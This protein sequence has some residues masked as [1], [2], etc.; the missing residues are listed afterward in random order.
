MERI[1]THTATMGVVSIGADGH[2]LVNL[3]CVSD[4]WRYAMMYWTGTVHNLAVKHRLRTANV[5]TYAAPVVV[6]PALRRKWHELFGVVSADGR[7]DTPVPYLYNQSVGT[8]LYTRIFRDLGIN[9]RHLLHLQHQTTHYA[10]VED[11]IAADRQ[12]L[13]CSLQEAWRLGDGKALIALRI[14]IHR[15]RDEGGEM[16][17]TV[18]DRFMIRSVPKDDLAALTSGRSLL[19]SISGLR[20]REPQLETTAVGTKV[21]SI[22]LPEDM[23]RR[24]GSVSGDYNPVH[25]TALAARMFGM[26]RPFVQ[27]LCLRNAMLRELV[28]AGFPLTRFQMSFANPA[29]LGQSLQ[30]VMQDGAFEVIDEDRHVIAFGSATDAT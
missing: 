8:L 21:A 11:W 27:G 23:G 19:R 18:N 24:F 15:P 20:K 30:F 13:H 3:P 26:K 4:G 5:R 17:G 10:A 1:S 7:P 28:R 14:A 12:E 2:T 6:T 9:F 29:Y 22:A 16:L 25:T